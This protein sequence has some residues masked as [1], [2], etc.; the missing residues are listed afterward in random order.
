M[1]NEANGLTVLSG[2]EENSGVIIET[3]ER[4]VGVGDYNE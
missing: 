1:Y 2:G 4:E 3:K